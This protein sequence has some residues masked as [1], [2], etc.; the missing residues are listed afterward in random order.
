MAAGGER[1]DEEEQHVQVSPNDVLQHRTLST[2]LRTDDCNL[3]Q[4]DGVLNL[5][6]DI[7]SQY[8]CL[9]QLPLVQQRIT[10]TYSDGGE[11]ILQL[12]DERDQ[13]RIVDVDP[14]RRP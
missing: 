10:T 3:R 7:V 2:R 12:V 8:L 14:M 13:A 4:V 5:F 6:G 9:S 1:E 11:D